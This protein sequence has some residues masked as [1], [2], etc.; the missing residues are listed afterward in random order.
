MT[1]RALALIAALIASS[2]GDLSARHEE[3]V[4][5]AALKHYLAHQKPPQ[6]DP[7]CLAVGGYKAPSASLRRLLRG[8]KL[9]RDENC[10]FREGALVYSLTRVGLDS[11]DSGIWRGSRSPD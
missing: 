8:V 6:K 3:S 11:E 10:H 2:E 5:V 7:V 1:L 4:Q 9:N